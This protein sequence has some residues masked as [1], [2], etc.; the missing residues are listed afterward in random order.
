VKTRNWNAAFLLFMAL[1]FIF[2]FAGIILFFRNV[3]G[4]NLPQAPDGSQPVNATVTVTSIWNALL[5]ATPFAYSTPL[6]DPVQSSLDGIYSKIDQ[7]W[8]QWWKCYRCADYRLAG[9]I[10]RMQFDKGVMRIFYEVTGWRTIASFTT[11]NDHLYIFNDPYCPEDVGEYKWNVEDGQLDLEVIDD[12]CSFD[13][14]AKNLSHQSWSSC[15]FSDQKAGTSTSDQ[16]PPG[17][18]ENLVVPAPAV[19]ADLAV[20]VIVYGGDSRFFEKPPDVVANANTADRPSPDG[21]AIAFDNHTIPYGIHRILWWNGNWIEA[22]T[23]LP[24]S[25]TGVQ[26]F[27][28][29]QIGW[30]RVLFDGVEVWRGNTSAIWSKNARHGGYIEISGFG[31]GTHIL[32]VESLDFDYRPVTV[33]SFGYSYEGGVETGQP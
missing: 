9:G 11:S 33:V 28:E 18:E 16:K 22:S 15:A 13:L 32:R 8:P 26:F 4:V 2:V 19:P 1:I 20:N 24:F 3:N 5:K 6:P 10:W 17:C 23:D 31:P 21:V 29:Q 27:G 30:A 7:S 14:R 12:S 25:A